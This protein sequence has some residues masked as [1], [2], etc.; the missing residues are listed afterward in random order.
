MRALPS[1]CWPPRARARFP[2]AQLAPQSSPSGLQGVPLL[3]KLRS[4]QND[5]GG[6]ILLVPV[7]GG[8][9]GVIE[10]RTQLIELLLSDG[11][12]FVVVTDRATSREP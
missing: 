4:G 6:R 2:L 7:H 12:V 8:L 10:K 9:R 11:I 1:M 3:L 5:Y